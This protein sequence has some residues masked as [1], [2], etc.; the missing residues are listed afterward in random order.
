MT[1][2]GETMKKIKKLEL[3]KITLTTLDQESQ[4]KLV[5][6]SEPSKGQSRVICGEDNFTKFY[7]CRL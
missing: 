2:K 4:E 1:K 5:G 6:G 3:K 7:S